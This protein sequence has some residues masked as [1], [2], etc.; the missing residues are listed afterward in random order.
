[1]KLNKDAFVK[2]A[3][4]AKVLVLGD[5]MLDRYIYGD[6]TRISPEAP[7]PIVKVLQKKDMLG[8]AAN[9]AI[10]IRRLNVCSALT[11]TVGDDESGY[12]ILKL[13]KE[14][15][16]DFIGCV[17]RSTITKTR[18]IGKNQQMLRVDEEQDVSE[19]YNEH[20]RLIDGIENALK[21][22]QVLVISDYN[23]GVCAEE[24]C[25]K[26][27]R[28]AK[29]FCKTTI[30]DP[31]S[32][33]WEKYRGAD[34][35][36]PNFREFCEALRL[37]K[38]ISNT[39]EDI[40]F[41]AKKMIEKYELGAVLVTRSEKGMTYVDNDGKTMSFSTIAREVF[42][43]S[44]AGDTVVAVLS[45]FL[46]T[47]FSIID[48]VEYANVAAGISVGRM[49]TYSVS[50]DEIAK[51]FENTCL[52]MKEKI[53]S[54]GALKFVLETWRKKNETVVFT[55]GCFDILHSGHI[56]YLKAASKLGSKLIVGINTDSS[57]KRI[58]G[59]SRPINSEADRALLLSA[60]YFV[61]LIIFFDDDTPLELIKA[62]RP[63]VLTKGSDYRHDEVVGREYAKELVLIPFVEGFSS[64]SIIEKLNSTS[65]GASAG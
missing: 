33:N 27:I 46:A 21:D 13:L 53:V 25:K 17:S 30:V 44:G 26:V 65:S 35:I 14:K 7:V 58:K 42:D 39:V 64:T 24:L 10:N 51:C 62:I 56:Q 41:H 40:S 20:D 8:G 38:P 15:G 47:G 22:I 3:Q 48:S 2:K 11:G 50:L 63:D 6:V 9:V 34:I 49:G 23:K 1:M 18:I 45:A 36:T 55:N 12:T 57:V 28:S 59:E 19:C 61:D 4:D 5:V 37:D 60:L 52:D 31:K 43:V 32:I 54:L 16:I 29:K